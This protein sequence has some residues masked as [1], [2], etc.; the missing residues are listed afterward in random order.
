MIPHIEQAYKVSATT[1]DRGRIGETIGY[2]TTKINAGKAA[3]GVGWYGGAGDI[4][5]VWTIHHD[6]RIYVLADA[7]PI[8]LDRTLPE[9]REEL[10]Q[11]ALAKLNEDDKLALGLK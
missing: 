1:D 6:D 4:K 5:A 2:Y 10:R 3:K 11:K 7:Q 9:Y 8:V